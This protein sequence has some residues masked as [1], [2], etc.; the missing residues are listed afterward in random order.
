MPKEDGFLINTHVLPD[1]TSSTP[2]PDAAADLLALEVTQRAYTKWAMRCESWNH[3]QQDWLEAEAEIAHE[4]VMTG[5]LTEASEQIL[6][7]VAE[8][9]GADRRLVAEHAV[10]TILAVAQTLIDAA[11]KP[12]QA[13]G[14]CFDWDVGAV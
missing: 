3:Q 8:R 13:I 12:V 1:H 4:A 14:E 10:S 5:Q 7:L 9:K 6:S 11:P 2:L